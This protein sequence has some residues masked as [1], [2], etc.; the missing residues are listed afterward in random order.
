MKI[1]ID[2][3][4]LEEKRTGTSRYLMNLLKYW[5]KENAEFVLYFKNQ[6]PKDIPKNQNFQ[7]KIL[8][9]HSNAWF[10]HILLPRAIKKD[11]IDIF[12]SPSYILPLKILPRRQAGPKRVKTAVAIHDISY[13]AHPE[14]FSLTNRI[15]LRWVSKTS[16]RKADIIFVPSEFTKKEILK[17]YPSSCGAG[18][19]DVNKIHVIPLAADE[20]FVQ[21]ST[22]KRE[23]LIFYVGAIFNRRFIP[24]IIKAFKKI[25][26]RHSLGEGGTDKLPEYKLLIAGSNYT[27]PFIDIKSEDSI[28]Y[29]D[30]I[31]EKDLTGLYNSAELFIW[32]SSYEGFGLP[33]LEAMA[34]GTPVLSTKKTSL[35]EVLGDYPVWVDNPEDIDE[36]GEKILKVLSNERLRNDL[37]KKGLEQARKFSWQKTAK[38]TLRILYEK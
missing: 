23:K 16:A 24:Q 26:A 5:A 35:A 9:S 34:C 14:W 17:Y 3:H 11:R 21:N 30:Y 36:I 27:H 15:L 13:E 8:N 25:L 32:L 22:I 12:F 7:T 38:E 37:I 29:T 19:V 6:V 10:E 31:N 20:K 33:P 2:C 28:I 1:G 18:K 4:N